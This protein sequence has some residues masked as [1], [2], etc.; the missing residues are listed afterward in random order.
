MLTVAKIWNQLI[1]NF[2]KNFLKFLKKMSSTW[3]YISLHACTY[4]H[5]HSD[6]FKHKNNEMLSF[7][8]TWMELEDIVLSE[9]H[10]AQKTLFSVMCES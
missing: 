8:A 2:L 1:L 6:I 10:Q 9:I 5:T 4:T 3:V 7:V